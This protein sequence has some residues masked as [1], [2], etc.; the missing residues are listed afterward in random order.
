[1]PLSYFLPR[2]ER[3]WELGH[4]LDMRCRM[5]EGQ[6][7]QARVPEWPCVMSSSEDAHKKSVEERKDKWGGGGKL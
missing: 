5:Q 6:T 3:L 2:K 4:L 7:G 1:M